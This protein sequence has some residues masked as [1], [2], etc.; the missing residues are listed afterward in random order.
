M[1][2]PSTAALHVRA[3][4]WLR[5]PCPCSNRHRRALIADHWSF[6]PL[7]RVNLPVYCTMTTFAPT[8]QHQHRSLLQLYWYHA[9]VTAQIGKVDST[10][11]S[12][13]IGISV[14]GRHEALVLSSVNDLAGKETRPDRKSA[15]S[16]KSVSV[17]V[18]LG[19]SRYINNKKTKKK[20]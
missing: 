2:T 14:G 20:Q 3:R 9:K 17:R 1:Q 10:V 16:G 8:E 12:V 7:H 18:T 19:G 5:N 11:D 15:V 13:E 6:P 4:T